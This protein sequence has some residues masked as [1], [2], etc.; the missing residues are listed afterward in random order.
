MEIK[1][2]E[3]HD[4][5]LGDPVDIENPKTLKSTAGLWPDWLPYGHAAFMLMLLLALLLGYGLP[6]EKPEQPQRDYRANY[7][8]VEEEKKAV[9]EY[10]EKVEAYE[11]EKKAWDEG[12]EESRR[13]WIAVGRNSAKF[14]SSGQCS[15]AIKY[16]GMVSNFVFYIFF[17]HLD[18]C[19]LDS[20]G[21]RSGKTFGIFCNGASTRGTCSNQWK[22]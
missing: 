19:A 15:H 16:L 8:S 21:N 1:K 13:G 17:C 7:E 22:S 12:G 2:G 9:K 11:K 3:S 6:Y 18:F 4:S 14:S 10:D 20:N 5:E